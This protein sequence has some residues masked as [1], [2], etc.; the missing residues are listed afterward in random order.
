MSYPDKL[1]IKPEKKSGLREI[2]AL[3]NPNTYSITKSVQWSQVA[4]PL[5]GSGKDSSNRT[6]NAPALSFGGGQGRQLTLD[7]LFDSTEEK[8]QTMLDVRSRTKEIVALTRIQRD[9]GRP[10]VCDVTWGRAGDP[11]FPF[12]GVVSQLTQHLTLFRA[13]GTAL[14]A[15]LT[16]AFTECLAPQMDLRET[17]PEFTT[18]LVKRGDS[19]SGISGEVYGDPTMW[20]Q[21][22]EANQLDDP[23]LLAIGMRLKIPK[24]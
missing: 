5:S 13:N 18:R 1:I 10:P 6:T 16:V 24:A 20:R 4:A 23:R 9:L 12:T 7:L 15:T 14:R 11:D 17:D 2:E 21:I 3:F 22:A 8:D 19:L